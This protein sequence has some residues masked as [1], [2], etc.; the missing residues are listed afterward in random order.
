G[1]PQSRQIRTGI[2]DRL[3]VQVLAGLEE[4]DRLLMAAP[5]GSDS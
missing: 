5:D 3:R 1:K 4:G 2:S